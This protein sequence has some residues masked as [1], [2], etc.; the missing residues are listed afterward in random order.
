IVEAADTRISVWRAPDDPYL[1]GLAAAEDPRFV[2]ELVD[3]LG[4]G[5]GKLIVERLRYTPRSRAIVFVAREPVGR[6][7]AFVPGQGFQAPEPEPVLY[8]KVLRPERAEDLQRAHDALDG[9]IP[10]AQR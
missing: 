1:P 8:L 3:G 6:G 2:A 5:G 10:A 7:L 9:L 4:L